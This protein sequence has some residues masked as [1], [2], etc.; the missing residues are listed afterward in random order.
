MITPS[1]NREKDYQRWKGFFKTVLQDEPIL[2]TTSR[3][4]VWKLNKCTLWHYPAK[5]KKYGIPIFI[6]YSLINQPYILDLGPGNS[7]IEFLTSFGFDVYLLDFGVPGY[8]D[9]D[10]RLDDYISYI[11][12]G[13]QR[14]LD[15]SDSKTITLIGFCMGGT[16]ATIYAAVADEP[17][18]NLVLIVTPIDFTAIKLYRNWFKALKAGGINVSSLI[19]Q[20]GLIPA[21]YVEVGMRLITSPLYFSPYF[22]LL[23]KAYDESYAQNWFR[24]NKWSKD[25]IPLPGATAYQLLQEFG[26][27]NSLINNK[28]TI[29]GKLAALSNIKANLLAICNENDRMVPAET[30]E[31]L[32]SHVSSDDKYF[33]LTKGGHATTSGELPKQLAKWLPHRSNPLI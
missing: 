9:K 33:H 22:S 3:T 6:V 1:F 21:R 13:V 27:K 11:Q 7:M 31:P 28:L 2:P 26:M 4:A 32:M 19:Q 5:E 25:H 8:E 12:K 29:N 14:S 30:C 10:L 24:F 18:E 23:N 17:I 15:H 20:T 16:L